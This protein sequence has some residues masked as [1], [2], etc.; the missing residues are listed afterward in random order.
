MRMPY[1]PDAL[2]YPPRWCSEEDEGGKGDRGWSGGGDER[3]WWRRIFR[4]IYVFV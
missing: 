2:Y 1:R 4:M 3:R